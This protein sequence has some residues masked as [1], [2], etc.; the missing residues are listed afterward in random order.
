MILMYYPFVSQ[1]YCVL[2]AVDRVT[3]F[4]YT[5]RLYLWVNHLKR[6]KKSQDIF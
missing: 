6:K 4:N 5:T 2:N 3:I 1:I